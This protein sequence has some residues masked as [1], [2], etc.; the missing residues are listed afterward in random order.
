MAIFSAFD[1]SAVGRL[2]RT[3]EIVG[4]RTQQTLNYIRKL[5]G[6]N[7]NFT[8]YRE[9]I[10]SVNP[11]C[12][13]F[14]GIYLQDLTFIE[15]GNPD[16]LAKSDDLINFAKRQKTAEVIREIKQFQSSPYIL[17]EVPGIQS[18]IKKSL[19]A[20]LDVEALYE[21]SLELEPRTT[22]AAAEAARLLEMIN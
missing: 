22:T 1:N 7:R 13:P 21:R 12:I 18:F 17:Q 19:E 6:A 4:N 20:S 11:P 10:H 16:Y 9:M 5:M 15:D 14:L 3:W 8:E 2:R